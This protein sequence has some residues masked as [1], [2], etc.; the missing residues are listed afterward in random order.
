MKPPVIII[1]MHRSGTSML[2]RFI[3]DSGVFMGSKKSMGP[4]E[5]AFFF[6]RLNEWILFQKNV[7][8]D[9]TVNLKFTNE[10]INENLSRTIKD[11]LKSPIKT[12]RY[13]GGKYNIIGKNL[14]DLNIMWGWK[15]PKNTLTLDIWSKIYPDAKIVHIYRNPI[16]VAFSLQSREKRIS[17]N[18]KRNKSVKRKEENLKYRYAYNQSL[19]VL[20][21]SE[22]VRLWEE[23]IEKAFAAENYFNNILHIS[24]EQ[25]LE[26]PEPVLISLSNFLEIK[27]DH[28][29]IIKISS[30]I[31]S[32]RMYAFT[33]NDEL[34]AFY[35]SIKDNE[36]LRKL[37]YNQI[38]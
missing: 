6:Q 18:F 30:Q 28:S 35:K 36:L 14:L 27:I 10:F 37:N 5:E 32:R 17:K 33:Q 12:R 24:Y 7:T 29:I 11:H 38:I 16:D 20:E 22:G 13:F 4:N 1:G 2:T 25:F 23:Y 26:N 21:L 8:W 9:N 34:V 3:E 31:I 15:D 19:R